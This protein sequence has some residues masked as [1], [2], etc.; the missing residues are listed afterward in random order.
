MRC[1]IVL[2][3]AVNGKT[4]RIDLPQSLYCVKE[5]LGSLSEAYDGVW[6]VSMSTFGGAL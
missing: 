3:V 2:E 1:E 5:W 6:M 4:C